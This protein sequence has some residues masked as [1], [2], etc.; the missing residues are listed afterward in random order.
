MTKQREQGYYWITAWEERI[1]A[2]WDS[3]EWFYHNGSD[4]SIPETAV[5]YIN[6]NRIIEDG[7]VSS[8][9]EYLEKEGL[10]SH[11]IGSILDNIN[12]I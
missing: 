5:I 2:Y 6:E 1:I 8:M 3:C 12:G 9:R 4:M 10:W 7:T 11:Y